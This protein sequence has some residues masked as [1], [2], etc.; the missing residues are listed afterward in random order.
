MRPP[1]IAAVLVAALAVRLAGAAPLA[2][3]DYTR[4][5]SFGGHARSYLLHVPPSYDGGSAVPLVL[6]FHGFTSNALQQ[7]ALSG[8][9]PVS[10][11]EGFL[12]AHPDGLNHAW[13]A[14][15]CCGNPDIDDVG[16]VRAVVADIRGAAAIDPGHVYATGLSNGGAISQRLA[17][18]AADL[19]AATA[20]MAFPVPAIPLTECRPV[21]VIP[22]LTFMGLTD[23]L[24]PYWGGPFGS[25]PSTLEYWVEIDGCRGDGPDETVV[26]GASRCETYTRCTRGAA[27]GLCSITARSFG[28]A[29]F[30][31]HIL[32]VNPDFDLPEVAWAFFSRFRLA[33]AGTPQ[34]LTLAGS[35]R[36]RLRGAGTDARS[37]TWSLTVGDGTW[38]ATTGDGT[39]L[40]GSARR[41]RRGRGAVLVPTSAARAE[42]A[43]ALRP[44]VAA[45]AGADAEPAI[46]SGGVLTLTT[47]ARRARL[48]GTL[49]LQGAT[50]AT[51]R[52]D[53]AGRRPH[54]G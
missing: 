19:F 44:R 46:A 41:R 16:F 9:V 12:L 35:D 13:N 42:L 24:V 5:L 36:L 32:Y 25:A 21:R 22:V 50:R 34:T 47:S 17:C 18:D 3:G 53:V 20:P 40:A 8:W 52:I 38:S 37:V 6:D 23:V 4:P 1:R 43:A 31:G 26:Q 30:D 15:T 2:P 33:E 39:L 11:R 51:Y 54:G 27:A 49:H 10:D 7:R 28:G 48:T 45:L 29:Y 14:G